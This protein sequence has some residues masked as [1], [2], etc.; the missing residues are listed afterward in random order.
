VATW[1][2]ASRTQAEKAAKKLLT[3]WA[4]PTRAYQQWWADLKPL[5]SAAA[6]E[7]YSYTDPANVPPLKITGPGVLSDSLS[8]YLVTVTFPTTEGEFGVDMSR[9]EIPGKWITEN[10]IFPGDSSRLQG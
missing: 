10:I 8:P 6:Q 3:T 2:A 9:T 4:R 7:S 5:M 1:D